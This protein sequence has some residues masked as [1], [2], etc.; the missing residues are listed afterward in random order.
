MW[1]DLIKNKNSIRAG[2]GIKIRNGQQSR[3][4]DWQLAVWWG[5]VP[6]YTGDLGLVWIQ[7]L[8]ANWLKVSFFLGAKS[9]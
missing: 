5:I 6:S 7:G 9:D 8:K 3:I 1:Y 2:R 4:W